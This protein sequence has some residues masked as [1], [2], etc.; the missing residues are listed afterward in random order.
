MAIIDDKLKEQL[1]D[2]FSKELKGNVKIWL[3]TS[4]SEGRCQYCGVVEDLVRELCSLNEKL[5]M[6]LYDIDD[7]PKEAEVLG[8]ERVPAILLHGASAYGIYYYGMPTGYEFGSLVDDI[9]DVSRSRSGLSQE[10]KNALRGI[11]KKVDIKVF[12]TPTCPYCPKAVRTAHQMALENGNVK[13]SMIEAME[14]AALSEKYGVMGVPKVVIN[15][16]ISFEGAVSEEAF[17]EQVRK[18]LK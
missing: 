13:A 18:A 8:I 1:R 6:F 9:M 15:D 14:F 16:S 17:V 7:H 11:A 3:F 4:K 5:G 12:V 10:S 2:T